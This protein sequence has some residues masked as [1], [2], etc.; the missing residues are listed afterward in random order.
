MYQ[1]TYVKYFTMQRHRHL[2]I[3]T[4]TGLSCARCCPLSGWIVGRWQD[5]QEGVP[6][7]AASGGQLPQIHG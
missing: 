3:R 5:V 1:G 6:P 2:P 4:V 7:G